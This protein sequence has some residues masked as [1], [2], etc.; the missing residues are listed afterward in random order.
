MDK[1]KIFMVLLGCKPAGRNTEQHD[2]FFGVGEKLADL[3]EDMVKF[4]PEAETEEKTLHIDVWK[5]IKC[6]DGYKITAFPLRSGENIKAKRS[7]YF[8]NFGAYTPNEFEEDHKKILVV[9]ES[10][11]LAKVAALKHP[12]YKNGQKEKPGSRSHIDDKFDI[13]DVIK[14]DIPGHRIALEKVSKIKA[15]HLETPIHSGYLPM[16][17]IK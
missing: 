11:E 5:E 7:L 9:A 3:K 14:V 16:K 8:I 12:F 13:D 17:L 2:I 15:A 10:I 4:W 1:K 6:V